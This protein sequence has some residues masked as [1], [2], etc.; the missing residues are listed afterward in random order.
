MT[1][2]I[3]ESARNVEGA[4]RGMCSVCGGPLLPGQLVNLDAKR[5]DF[6]CQGSDWSWHHADCREER[7][8]S[9]PGGDRG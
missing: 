8:G 7:D 4:S 3:L 1:N 9:R 6:L 2:A 5:Y